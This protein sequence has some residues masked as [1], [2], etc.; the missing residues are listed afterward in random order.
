MGSMYFSPKPARMRAPAPAYTM[1]SVSAEDRRDL[2]IGDLVEA[3][4]RS[5]QNFRTIIE[6]ARPSHLCAAAVLL[7][8]CGGTVS[9]SDARGDAGADVDAAAHADASL[10]VVAEASAEAEASPDSGSC[11]VSSDS[12]LPGVTIAF[13][14]PMTCH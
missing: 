6:R 12:T 4:R 8:G 13:R 10:D 3:L 1:R 7:T 5:E 14:A 11:R 2:G 9:S